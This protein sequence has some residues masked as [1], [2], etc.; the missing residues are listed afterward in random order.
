MS[1]PRR[2]MRCEH[3]SACRL[4]PH[5]LPQ[6]DAAH[7]ASFLRCPPRP[8]P[9]VRRAP[10]TAQGPS[11]SAVTSTGLPSDIPA[12]AAGPSQQKRWTLPML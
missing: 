9:R 5:N 3:A 6:D 2:V 7:R 10:L 11:Q 4:Q 8:P 12:L 1:A